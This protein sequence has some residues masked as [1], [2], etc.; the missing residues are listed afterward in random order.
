[1]FFDADYF[2][3]KRAICHEVLTEVEW[4]LPHLKGTSILDVACGAGRHGFL[5]EYYGFKVT[6]FDISPD[7]LKNVHWSYRKIRGNFV[8]HDFGAAKFDNVV[9]F[10]FIEHL[11]D[12]QLIRT[13][14]KMK[15]LAKYR[16]INITPH[17]K[18]SQ[19]KKDPTHVYRPYEKLL[20]L[21]LSVLPDTKIYTYDNKH[22]G[23]PIAW[24]KGF[25]ERMRPH[26]FENLMFVTEVG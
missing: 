4:V 20:E 9:S 19:F 14:K 3:D 11:T 10:H 15:N 7:A 16:V 12:E 21:Y 26:Y 13:L 22:R 18:H 6:Y 23:H 8:E 2:K 25:F 17:P 5:L 24:L 1:M